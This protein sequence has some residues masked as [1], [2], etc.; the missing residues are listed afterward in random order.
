MLN[1]ATSPRFIGRIRRRSRWVPVASC[2]AGWTY[3]TCGGT[4][5]CRRRSFPAS[6]VSRDA[7][8]VRSSVLCAICLRGASNNIEIRGEQWGAWTQ[9]AGWVIS[10]VYDTHFATS[11]FDTHNARRHDWCR[12][13]FCAFL[14][15]KCWKCQSEFTD[16]KD[17]AKSD[18]PTY[19]HFICGAATYLHSIL[20]ILLYINL[21]ISGITLRS[22]RWIIIIRLGDVIA[23]RTNG[24]RGLLIV[25][26]TNFVVCVNEATAF[27]AI[28]RCNNLPCSS[29]PWKRRT[30]LEETRET[31]RC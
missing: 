22:N 2:F 28:R 14:R 6:R 23:Q 4:V 13:T 17:R 20:E 8:Y 5:R 27:R 11:H 3:I 1:P 16:Y 29:V 15:R 26:L 7:T 18:K 9:L 24:R 21:K 19:L 12:A 30:Y 31:A 25:T 10:F